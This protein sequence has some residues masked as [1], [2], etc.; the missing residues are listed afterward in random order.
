MQKEDVFGRHK[1]AHSMSALPEKGP[2]VPRMSRRSKIFRGQLELAGYPFLLYAHRK[3]F[4]SP[5]FLS[6][7]S[8]VVVAQNFNIG[9]D[10]HTNAGDTVDEDTCIIAVETHEGLVV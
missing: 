7:I 10:T 2:L 8:R 6:I 1:E 4:I 3:N 5:S 9:S